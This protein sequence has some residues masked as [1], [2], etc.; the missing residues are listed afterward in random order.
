MAHPLAT[1]PQGSGAWSIRANGGGSSHGA[2]TGP[3]PMARVDCGATF[4]MAIGLG[5]IGLHDQAVALRRVPRA[6]GGPR[7]IHQPCVGKTV[8]WTV[9]RSASPMKHNTAP[10]P[11]D[12]LNR[13]APGSVVEG[14]WH[15]SASHPG[16][17]F[18]QCG[19]GGQGGSSD[20]RWSGVSAGVSAGREARG[21][22][23]PLPSSGGA[24]SCPGWKR[25]IDARALTKVPS[26]GKCASDSNGSTSRCARIAARNLRDMSVVNSRSRF[27]GR[28]PS[29]LRP[30]RRCQARQTSRTSGQSGLPSFEFTCAP[31]RVCKSNRCLGWQSEY[32]NPVEGNT[33]YTESAPSTGAPC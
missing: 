5:Q 27:L 17:R 32:L 29:E 18:R 13:H 22:S 31:E 30:D 19:C 15:S 16:S 11:A 14:R 4:G 9:F 10:V 24:P 7:L 23:G 33:L 8:H 2:A 28:T 25:F 12:V 1:R 26:T 20:W 21:F 3:R 6:G